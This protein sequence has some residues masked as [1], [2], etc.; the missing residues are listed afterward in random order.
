[1]EIQK[2]IDKLNIH[3]QKKYGP[4]VNNQLLF[5]TVI[6]NI[7]GQVLGLAYSS[8]ESLKEAIEQKKGI[9]YSRS[10]NQI[11]FKSPSGTDSQ[12][13]IDIKFSCDGTSLL[14]TVKQRGVFCHEGCK[15]CFEASLNE[16]LTRLNPLEAIKIGICKGKQGDMS[17]DLLSSIGIHICKNQVPRSTNFFVKSDLYPNMQLI[18]IRSGDIQTILNNKMLDIVICYDN[19]I[20]KTVE[21]TLIKLGKQNGIHPVKVVAIKRSGETIHKAPTIFSEYPDLTQEWISQ[22]YSDASVIHVHGGAETFLANGMCDLAVVVKDSGNTL[23]INN[24][25]VI[26]ILSD[27]DLYMYITLNMQEKHPNIVRLIRNRLQNKIIYFFSVDD[28]ESGFLSNFYPAKFKVSEGEDEEVW[29]S[30]EHYYHAHKFKH[31]KEV[32]LEIK[33]AKTAKQAYKIAKRNLDKI[34]QDW[35]VVKEFFMQK[36]IFYKFSQNQNLKQKLL[37]TGSREL[38]EYSIKDPYWGIGI[39]DNGKN[40]LG[41]LL[42]ELR[43]MLI[44]S[45]IMD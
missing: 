3:K 40:R 12:D 30:S 33:N 20:S 4:F 27:A 37:A 9:Y 42:M 45:E 32:Y 6:Q 15:S 7:D 18:E 39:N 19:V 24:L 11:W 38:I 16:N 13:L 35:E 23:K 1:M 44:S 14:F 43:E 25:E 31:N 22:N 26:D 21:E 36:A 10:R 29:K 2:Y 5:P 17:F 41:Q 8:P 28:V 34:R